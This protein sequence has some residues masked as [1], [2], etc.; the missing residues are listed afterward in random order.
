MKFWTARLNFQTFRPIGDLPQ[1]RNRRDAVLMRTLCSL[2]HDVQSTMA[3]P[4]YRPTLHTVQYTSTS[5]HG[6]VCMNL[7]IYTNWHPPLQRFCRLSLQALPN[8]SKIEQTA[9]GLDVRGA[10]AVDAVS[11]VW[12][13]LSLTRRDFLYDVMSGRVRGDVFCRIFPVCSWMSP[14]VVFTNLPVEKCSWIKQNSANREGTRCEGGASHSGNLN[15]NWLNSHISSTLLLILPY[16]CLFLRKFDKEEFGL[17]LFLVIMA[18]TQG[19]K[20]DFPPT[21]FLLPSATEQSERYQHSCI[22]IIPGKQT[23]AN[24]RSPPL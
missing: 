21:D 3:P 11:E 13:L 2:V 6:W 19:L 5:D 22:V 8:K 1:S 12:S 17:E 7:I 18:R 14:A 24:D 23:M 10:P 20:R 9:K 4:F 15:V 16:E